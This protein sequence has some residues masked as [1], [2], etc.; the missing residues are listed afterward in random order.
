[1]QITT[2]QSRNHHVVSHS[3]GRWPSVTINVL[4]ETN[5][6]DD[7]NA[8]ICDIRKLRYTFY[9]NRTFYCFLSFAAESYSDPEHDN[10]IEDANEQNLQQFSSNPTCNF[11]FE[12]IKMIGAP[13][14]RRSYCVFTC[15]HLCARVDTYVHM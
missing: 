5:A 6:R 10:Q 4:I 14:H 12:K 1:M 7:L 11:V 3:I 9:T 13:K 8:T 2:R 15:R